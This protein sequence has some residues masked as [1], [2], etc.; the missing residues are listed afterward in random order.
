MKNTKIY[1]GAKWLLAIIISL[2]VYE[3]SL[4]DYVLSRIETCYSYYLISN[5]WIE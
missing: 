1:F 4:A 3:P 2:Y 5:S